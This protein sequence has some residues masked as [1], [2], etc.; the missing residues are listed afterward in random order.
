MATVKVWVG[1]FGPYT[2]S[3]GKGLRTDKVPAEPEDVLRLADVGTEVLPIGFNTIHVDGEADL[4]A[5]AGRTTLVLVEGDH[6]SLTTD[7]AT[8]SVTISVAPHASSHE[9]GGSDP[10]TFYFKDN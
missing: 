10:V 8:N 1:S 3:K 4:V 7:P 5:S 2:S 9:P 6:I